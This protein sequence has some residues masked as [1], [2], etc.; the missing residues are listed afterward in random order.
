MANVVAQTIS[1][2]STIVTETFCTMVSL[3]EGVLVWFL[4][5]APK[6]RGF[7]DR[8]A[9]G[10]KLKDMFAHNQSCLGL[11]WATLSSENPVNGESRA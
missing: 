4:F 3:F 1:I 7:R 2:Y 11:E 5:G 9:G 8:G 10:K 6:G